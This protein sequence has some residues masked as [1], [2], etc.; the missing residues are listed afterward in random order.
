M[1]ENGETAAGITAAPGHVAQEANGPRP[2][3]VLSKGLRK[4]RGR[5]S[6]KAKGA[7]CSCTNGWEF[8]LQTKECNTP[9]SKPPFIF[10][11][12]ILEIKSRKSTF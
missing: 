3:P 12:I 9:Y 1:G 11:Y 8:N 2:P 10:N 7:K 4:S 6:N 5:D